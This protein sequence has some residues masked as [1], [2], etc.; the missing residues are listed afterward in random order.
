MHQPGTILDNKYQ[1][2][3]VVGR[4]GFGF[5]Y[6]ARERLTGETVAIKELV[7]RFVDNPEMV[8][9][10]IQEARATLRL[11]HSHIARTYGIFHDR[12]TYYLAMEYLPG[13]SLADRLERGPLP[14]DQVVRV[15]SQLCEALHYAHQKGVVHCDIKPANVLFDQD[16]GVQL[17][18]FGIAHVSTE[19]MT[20]QFHTASGMAMGTVQYMAPE[21]LSGARDD[22]RIDVYAVGVLL[23]RMLAG[24]PYLGFQTETTP[25]AQAHNINLIQRQR[26]TPLRQIRPEVPE[27][28]AAAVDRALEK[29][30][31]DRFP[32]AEAMGR[33]LTLEHDTRGRAEVLPTPQRPVDTARRPAPLQESTR[34]DDHLAPGDPDRAHG[35]KRGNGPASQG[36]PSRPT[37][38]TYPDEHPDTR[39][40][41]HP[42]TRPDRQ[43]GSLL[44]EIPVWAW[45]AL[46][47]ATLALIVAMG[48]LA[49]TALRGQQT[50][51]SASTPAP[52]LETA[53]RQ[54]TEAPTETASPTPANTPTRR[55]AETPAPEAKPS[56][57]PSAAS[58]DT[59]TRPTDGMVMVRVPPGE[60]A[61]G[62]DDD[63]A[64]NAMAL[65]DAYS[66]ECNRELIAL[67]QPAHEVTLNGFWID[68][69]EVTNAQYARCVAAGDCEESTYAD[70]P[71]L[72]GP[73]QPAV[74]IDWYNAEAYCAWAGGR[75]PT[76]A[77]W[78]FAARGPDGWVFPWGDAFDQ[79]R[80]NFCDVNCT[81]D[82]KVDTFDDGH[83]KTAP[84]GSYPR[85]ASWC[86]ALDMAGNAWEWVED[87]FAPYPSAETLN[88]ANPA[89]GEAKVLRGGSWFDLPHDVR[90]TSRGKFR[91]DFGLSIVGCRCATDAP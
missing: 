4:G 51:E 11:K 50:S 21:Q 74:G 78:E 45:G 84:V 89:S 46:G 32:S 49:S 55:P 62:S 7:P 22:P 90:S 91:P 14:L 54:P 20:R 41:T 57:A 77:E 16:D 70:D 83:P 48:L 28:L 5:V 15:A 52:V 68:Q 79:T 82:W 44:S 6:R 37:A 88:P 9:R 33:A 69:T 1:I 36:P 60:F 66:P 58:T 53:T 65:C 38:D 43:A 25:A 71:N 29:T 8:E 73:D 31:A 19:M 12:G 72:N 76:E 61:M 35:G 39:P 24:H 67:E 63:A 26:P 86:G 64:A 17:V 2:E 47:V 34:R 59:W 18:D 85:G 40:D 30:P 10:F 80:L 81:G 56:T 42:D 87:W 75:L 3:G 27:G 13:G 23:Y